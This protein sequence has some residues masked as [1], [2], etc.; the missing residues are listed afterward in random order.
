MEHR[1][2]IAGFGGQGVQS[3]GQLICYAGIHEGKN[4]SWLPS[5]GPEMRGG[6]TNCSVIVS[7]EPIGAPVLTE[8]NCVMVLNRP[9]LDKFEPAVEPGGRLYINTSLIDRK[10][11]REDIE[12]IYIPCDDLANE[13]GNGRVA[14]MIMLGAFIEA[15]G[16]VSIDSVIEALKKVLGERKAH[17]IPLNRE[18]LERGAKIARGEEKV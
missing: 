1:I 11:E 5:Y 10:A 14:N 4:V 9:S 13:M 6:T 2:I 12:V 8:G 15:T 18:A 17:L 7:D 3:M 16:I